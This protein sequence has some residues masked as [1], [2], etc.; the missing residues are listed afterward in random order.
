MVR[1]WNAIFDFLELGWIEVLLGLGVFLSAS[2]GGL[3]LASVLLVRLPANYFADSHPREL[4]VNRH[5]VLRWTGLVAKNV[6]GV[7]VV[8]VGIMLSMPGVPG[9]GFLTI[10]IG[11]SLLDF[12]GKRCLERRLIGRSRVLAA[13]NRLRQRYGRLPLVLDDAGLGSA[14]QNRDESKQRALGQ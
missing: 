6:L 10:L 7:F 5:P 14:E 4:W 1:R 9:P 13:I 12:P 8:A 2:A 11:V 3:A